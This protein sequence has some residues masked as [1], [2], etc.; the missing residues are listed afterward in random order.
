MN[1][2]EAIYQIWC[3]LNSDLADLI[4]NEADG[5]TPINEYINY[6]EIKELYIVRDY[7]K[8]RYKHLI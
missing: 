5:I 2:Q 8:R 1:E 6:E 3:Q 4:E 7:L